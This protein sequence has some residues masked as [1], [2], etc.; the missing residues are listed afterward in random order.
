MVTKLQAGPDNPLFGRGALSGG[1]RV[2]VEEVFLA[3]MPKSSLQGRIHGVFWN[4][5]P[6][7]ATS[8]GISHL[9]QLFQYHINYFKILTGV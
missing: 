6:M 3:G 4:K 7:V 9:F 2:F 8:L 5:Y 1:C